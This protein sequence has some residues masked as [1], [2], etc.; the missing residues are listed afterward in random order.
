MAGL[1]KYKIQI[2][3][4]NKPAIRNPEGES[5]LRDLILRHGYNQ[6]KSVRTAKVL[7]L[8]VESE[9]EDSAKKKVIE[10][11][12]ELRIFNPLVSTCTVRIAGE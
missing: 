1:P 5:I 11:C 7:E 9:S 2:T 10:M 12:N 4:S 3:I 6:I 8:E